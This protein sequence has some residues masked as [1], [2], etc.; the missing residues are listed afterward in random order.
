MTY[1]A[2]L[3]VVCGVCLLGGLAQAGEGRPGGPGGRGGF[4]RGPRGGPP[5]AAQQK[6]PDAKPADSKAK[7]DAAKPDA[8]RP[9]AARPDAAK[10]DAAKPDAAKPAAAERTLAERGVA[11]RGS[12]F[13]RIPQ[14]LNLTGAQL[15][16]YKKK[17]AERNEGYAKWAAGER[18]KAYA[19]A[20]KQYKETKQG[21]KAPQ[22]AEVEKKYRPLRAE[23]EA[24]RKELRRQFNAIFTPD[25][26]KIWAGHML[27]SEVMDKLGRAAIGDEQKREIH[28]ACSVLAAQSLSDGDVQRDPYLKPDDQAIAKATEVV[29]LLIL[30]P[31]QKTG[32]GRGIASTR[33]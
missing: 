27:Y 7:P 23:Q 4:G 8:A 11:A 25:Q 24:V 17:L 3:G 31:G 16:T 6:A 13:D 22:V 29:K 21:G 2:I 15:E 33:Q 5:P 1:R 14:V 9:D 28:V 30:K 20:E 18:G 32:G 10:P 12:D 19:A 26:L